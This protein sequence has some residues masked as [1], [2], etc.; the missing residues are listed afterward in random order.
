MQRSKRRIYL[1]ESYEEIEELEK[2]DVQMMYENVRQVTLRRKKNLKHYIK[3]EDGSILIDE[4]ST[5]RRWKDNIKGL[6]AV[7]KKKK[8]Q[9]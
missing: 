9:R 2:K 1:K 7:M 3:D 4:E 5:K 8:N 6:Y